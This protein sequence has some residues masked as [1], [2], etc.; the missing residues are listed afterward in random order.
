MRHDLFASH[1]ER[2]DTLAIFPVCYGVQSARSADNSAS[3]D[4]VT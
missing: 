4:S 2:K 3:I 1:R